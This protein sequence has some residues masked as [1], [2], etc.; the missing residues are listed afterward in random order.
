M[1]LKITATTI[2]LLKPKHLTAL[3]CANYYIVVG[4]LE[5]RFSSICMTNRQFLQQAN[6]LFFYFWAEVINDV[7]TGVDLN[8]SVPPK[9]NVKYSTIYKNDAI[10]EPTN[11]EFCVIKKISL[12]L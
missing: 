9:N 3:K 11:D 8:H 6:N 12:H 1:T 7:I 10:L 4:S 5:L 2:Q